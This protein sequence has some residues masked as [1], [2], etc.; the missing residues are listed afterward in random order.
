MKLIKPTEH[1]RGQELLGLKFRT[2]LINGG[3]TCKTIRDV[4]KLIK[5][6]LGGIEIGSITYEERA[7]NTG[8]TFNCTDYCSINSIGMNNMGIMRATKELPIMIQMIH[9]AGKV[10]MVNVAGFNPMEYA[11]LTIMAFKAGADLVILNAGCPNIWTEESSG[12]TVQK[13]ILSFN[14]EGLG[15][16]LGIVLEKIINTPCPS[17]GE[18][19]H[20]NPGRVLLKL[21]PELNPLKRVDIMRRINARPWIGGVIL[22]NTKPNGLMLDKNLET[23]IDPAGGFGG[24]GG[25]ALQPLSLGYIKEAREFLNDD[26]IIIGAGGIETGHDMLAYQTVGAN[27]MQATTAYFKRNFDP[28]VFNEI[29]ADYYSSEFVN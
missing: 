11:E 23:M 6:D 21:S 27:L 9:D 5:T 8:T 19:Y 17:L 22:C 7:G 4:E 28:G 1:L 20:T 10:A 13:E 24:I 2:P 25:K 16:M 3:G 12:K 14:E 29:L 26:M 18:N 15:N